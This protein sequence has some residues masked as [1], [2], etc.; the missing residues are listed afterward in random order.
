MSDLTVVAVITAKQGSEQPVHDALA[1]LVAPTRNEDGCVSY[2]LYE[3]S[4]APGTFITVEAWKDQRELDAHMASEHIAAT[5]AAAGDHLAGQP[6]IH[7]LA[8]LDVT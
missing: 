6:A 3:S 5:F 4:T 8:P 2:D 7:V 1:A